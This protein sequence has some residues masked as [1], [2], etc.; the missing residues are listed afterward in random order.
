MSVSVRTKRVTA[1]FCKESRAGLRCAGESSCVGDCGA[2]T[3]LST[4]VHAFLET[5]GRRTPSV[6]SNGDGSEGDAT[7]PNESLEE[8]GASDDRDR[9]AMKTVRDLMFPALD[10]D[11]FR[12][13]LATDVS[14][15]AEALA[16][17]RSD[18]GESAYR[19][20]V[21]ARLRATGYNAGICK[22]RWDAS[23]G[24]AAGSYEFI[25]VVEAAERAGQGKGR[26]HI[27]DLDFAA[28]FEVARATEGYKAVVA[29]LPRV[30]VAGEE[31]VRRVVREVA[32]AARRSLRT[33]GL[34]VPPWRKSR[35]MLAKWL[36]PQRR[37]TSTIP[38]AALRGESKCREYNRFQAAPAPR[39]GDAHYRA[40]GFSAAPL[41]TAR[42]R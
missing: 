5:A 36:G 6:A 17:L 26:R 9:A 7:D 3:C 34:H 19:Q 39:G 29:A 23:G 27:V 14:R 40:V 28:E 41:P 33:Q 42:T 21:M 30:A 38:L 25:D 32:D 20:A 31:S 22:A 1:P 11:P 16:W 24:L 8:G 18:G 12:R 15:A 13:R 35:Y 10:P 37:T 4:Q 2:S